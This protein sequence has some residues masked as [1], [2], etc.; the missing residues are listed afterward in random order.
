[1][2]VLLFGDEGD[3]PRDI[4][5]KERPADVLKVLRRAEN[6]KVDEAKVQAASQVESAVIRI[7]K[8]LCKNW[9]V[10]ASSEQRLCVS[11]RR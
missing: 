3:V 9:V 6:A 7:V 1:M 11:A 10:S 8:F 5:Q 2:A 4:P